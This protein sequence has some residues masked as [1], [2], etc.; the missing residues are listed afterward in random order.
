MD[1]VKQASATWFGKGDYLLTVLPAGKDFD[2]AAEDKAVVARGE[3]AGK[4]APKLPAT[5]KFK[6]TASTLDRS[7]ACRRPFSS[8]T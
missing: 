5:G 7:R 8:P 1:S 6:V 3:E 4:P 2:P